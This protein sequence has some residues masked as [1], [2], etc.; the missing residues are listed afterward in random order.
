MRRGILALILV[1]A[2][3]GCQL[4]D[5]NPHWNPKAQLQPWCY[6]AP[7]YYRPAEDLQPLETVGPGIPVYYVDNEYFFV[8]HPAGTQLN[9]APRTAVWSSTDEGEHWSKQGYFGLEQTHFLCK[10][11]G[12]ANYFLRFV[13]PGQA[14]AELSPVMPHRI[15]V[16]DTHPPDLAITVEP[17][18]WVE[19]DCGE[20][21]PR[22]YKAGETI[23]VHWRVRDENLDPETV[24]VGMCF[25]KF[26]HNLVWG[27]LPKQLGPEGWEELVLPPEAAEHEGMR[28][29]VRAADKSGNVAI[30][31]TD[32]LHVDPAVGERAGTR[33][34]PVGPFEAVPPDQRQVEKPGW[35]L[36][37]AMLR[38]GTT[39]VLR[40]MPEFARKYEDIRLQ[41]STNDGRTWRTVATGLHYG[42]PARWTVPRVTTRLARLRLVARPRADQDPD[43]PVAE[44][45]LAMTRSFTVDT[46]TPDTILGPGPVEETSRVRPEEAEVE[47]E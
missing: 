16:V 1:M 39:Q 26:P 13:G 46:V 45:M 22:F 44:I 37:G 18:P 21:H 12:D 25:T 33:S 29:R 47:G 31:T 15:Y 19:D 27:D 24:R 4:Q 7:W 34:G 38:G 23:K 36:A 43:Q 3:A 8:K 42:E 6:D 41:F 11:D 35:P 17:S 20:R 5:E 14:A 9:A 10:A 30:A 40:W 2:A 28:F 32:V